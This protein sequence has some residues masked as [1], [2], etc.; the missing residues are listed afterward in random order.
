MQDSG[1]IRLQRA[2]AAVRDEQTLRGRLEEIVRRKGL[3]EVCVGVAVD[4]RELTLSAG[5]AEGGGVDATAASDVPV[6]AGCLAKSLTA[7]LVDEAVTAGRVGWTDAVADMLARDTHSRRHLAGITVRHLL[8]HAHGLDASTVHGVPRTDDGFIDVERL[9]GALGPQALF[10]PGRMYSY[11]HVGAWLAGAVLESVGGVR[12]V[13]QLRERQLICDASYDESGAICPATGAALTLTLAQWL[14]FA[15]R[16]LSQL[17][18]RQDGSR[19]VMALP[20]WHPTER[21]IWRGWK[22]YGDGWLG[23]NANLSDRSAMLRINPG[24]QLAIVVSASEANGA[25]FAASGVFGDLLPEFR[26]LRPPRLLK[27]DEV[28]G[29]SVHDHVGRYVQARTAVDVTLDAQGV[30]QL[31]VGER[32]QETGPASRLRAADRGVF[33]AESRGNPEFQFV[34]FIAHDASS[35]SAY[36]WNGRQIWRRESAV[37]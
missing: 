15:Q 1:D 12:Y 13:T 5:A 24:E 10:T 21:S 19:D 33:V 34:Q 35:G 2:M 14:G 7:T 22:C 20:G 17:Q 37:R 27:A 18:P 29:L 30:L 4:G 11:S 23:H 16:C 25:V 31:Q 8:D 3:Q 36:L 28:A 6:A 9:C 26:N 32:D